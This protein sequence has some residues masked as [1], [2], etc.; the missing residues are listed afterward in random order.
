MTLQP[1]ITFF[2]RT[3]VL[4]HPHV[5]HD[6]LSQC[7]QNIP[8]NYQ[9]LVKVSVLNRHSQFKGPQSLT[10]TTSYRM[11]EAFNMKLVKDDF[12]ESETNLPSKQL[13]ISIV[14]MG[15]MNSVP[16]TT[17]SDHQ[18]YDLFFLPS[19]MKHL[20]KRCQTKLSDLCLPKTFT[21][22]LCV[23]Q[24]SSTGLEQPKMATT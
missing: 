10:M 4:N 24:S 6:L 2:L 23:V 8:I 21:K 15:S 7:Q 3:N 22:K 9:I 14:R 17:I 12:E 20:L 13:L 1:N 11:P 18:D 19:N 16:K 5:P